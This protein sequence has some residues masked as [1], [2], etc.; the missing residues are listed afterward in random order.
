MPNNNNYVRMGDTVQ[1]TNGTG[2]DVAAGDHVV[3][4]NMDG[5]AQEDIADTNTGAVLIAGVHRMPKVTGTAWSPGD[6]LAWDASAGAFDL[7]SNI[8]LASGDV[9]EASVAA[10]DAASG[11]AEGDVLINV[12]LG[13]YTA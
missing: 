9:S 3:V 6:E 11:D 1:W 10:A 13:T 7:L 5:V 4:G 8:T 2:A 12:G